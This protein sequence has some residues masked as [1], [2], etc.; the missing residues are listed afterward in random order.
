MYLDNASTTKPYP[1][2]VLEALKYMTDC[3][4]NP[5]S[6]HNVGA[7]AKEAVDSAREKISRFIGCDE[8]QIIFTSSGSES[9]TLACMGIAEHLKRIGKRHIITTAVEHKS[10]INSMKRLEAEGFEVSYLPP[11]IDSDEF[12]LRFTAEIRPD[13]GFASV[14]CV[15]NETGHIFPI[16][17]I[18]EICH[19]NGILFHTD[20]TQ[21]VDIMPYP[22]EG[23]D[24]ITISAHKIGGIKGAA[25]LYARDKELLTPIIHGGENEYGL[26]GGTLNVPA[27]MAFA[28]AY[29]IFA[30][31]APLNIKS[32]SV[33]GALEAIFNGHKVDYRI[34]PA[35]RTGAHIISVTFPNVEAQTLISVLNEKG[36]Y[37]SAG[38]ACSTNSEEISHVLKAYGYTDK[39]ARETV[40]ISYPHLT[41]KEN[42]TGDLVDAIVKIAKTVKELQSQLSI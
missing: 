25:C 27:I 19:S 9:N 17:Q 36:V 42:G 5:E 29:S 6:P 28:K 15:N 14:M 32:D 39:E 40:R 7:S 31:N 16:E 4:G 23:I 37:I 18:A 35:S 21:G 13:T 11:F 3:F 33:I 26:R 24:F 41:E 8:E 2:A 20:C 38:S 10:V 12:L 34:H 1:E 22:R 30:Y